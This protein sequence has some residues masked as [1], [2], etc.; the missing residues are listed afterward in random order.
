MADEDP[1]DAPG[2]REVGEQH[3]WAFG[4]ATSGSAAEDPSEDPS[5]DDAEDRPASE[6]DQQR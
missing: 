2:A 3:V 1:L 6:E 4:A 5:E